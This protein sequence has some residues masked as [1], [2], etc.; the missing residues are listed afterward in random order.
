MFS[1]DLSTVFVYALLVTY[2]FSGAGSD[3]GPLYLGLCYIAD[4]CLYARYS[5]VIC[6][7]RLFYDMIHYHTMHF[8]W[9]YS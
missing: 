9:E 6:N 2:I 5:I 3:L 4:K 8:N 7:S 1:E